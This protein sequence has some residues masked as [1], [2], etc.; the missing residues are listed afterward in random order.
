MAGSATA[1][2]SP[3][4]TGARS[5]PTGGLL[6]KGS[7]EPTALTMHGKL[8]PMSTGFAI[9]YTVAIGL[10]CYLAATQGRDR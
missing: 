8:V 2:A 9:L 1:K 3:G 7:R 6:D 4:S 5:R 10:C